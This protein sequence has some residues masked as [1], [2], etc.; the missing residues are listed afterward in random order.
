MD[1]FSLIIFGVTSNLTQIKLIPALYDLARNNLLPDDF[2]IIGIA[3]GELST[4]DFENYFHQVLHLDNKHHRHKIHQEIYKK[5]CRHLRYI[6]GNFDDPHLYTSIK[7]IAG[8]KNNMYY[9][10]TYPE[11]YKQ[12]FDGL[13]K[14]N[15]NHGSNKVIIEK[16]I[17]NNLASA[18][19]LD[20]LL[21]SFFTENQIYRLDHY[22]GKDTLQNILSFRF[23][24]SIFEPL[25]NKNFIDHIQVSALE[26]FGIGKRGGYYDKVGALKDVGQNHLL[27]MIALTTMKGPKTF[28][29]KDITQERISILKKLKPLPNK[30]ILGQYQGYKNEDNVN[31]DS[32]TD[33]F[34]A[35]KTQIEN[36]RFR[37]VPIYVRAGKKLGMS[38]TEISIV[39]RSDTKEEQNV[40]IFRIQPNEGIV[41]KILVKKPGH[42]FEVVPTYMQFCYRDLPDEPADAYEKL[43]YD[44]MRGDQTF[45]NDAPEIE[46]QWKFIDSFDYAQDKPFLYAPGSWGPKEAD[47]LIE[48]DGRKWLE[49]SSI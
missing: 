35:F 41:M 33:T 37:G 4:Q 7:L 29:N 19:D 13:K 16:P 34:F 6:S 31:P 14:H 3:R 27:Q 15:L 46:A 24:N 38:A 1:P 18:K 42:K 5:L 47:L 26:D 49:P 12:I 20:K 39:F 36:E 23:G 9:L 43:I 25:F 45:F 28:S 32:K 21:L 10:A 30:L 22:L 17:G 2:S 44:A 8:S 11:L 48:A 40:L